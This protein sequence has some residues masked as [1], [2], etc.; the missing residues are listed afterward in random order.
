MNR[1]SKD[2]VNR[3]ELISDSG[4]QTQCLAQIHCHIHGNLQNMNFANLVNR[5]VFA[6]F[7]ITS[8]AICSARP[9][10]KLNCSLFTVHFV[11]CYFI[12]TCLRLCLLTGFFDCCT[13]VVLINLRCCVLMSINGFKQQHYIHSCVIATTVV[14]FCLTS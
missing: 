2:N 8:A 1:I 14:L 9:Q 4:V 13:M 11:K 3:C 12:S 10:S 6:G 5:N 7:I